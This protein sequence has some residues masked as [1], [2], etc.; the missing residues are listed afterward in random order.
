MRFFALKGSEKLG[1]AAARALA[2]ELDP[3]EE[4]DFEDGEH[5]ARPLVSVRGKDVYVL[6]SLA[7]SGGASAND[8]L[9]KLLFFLATCRENGAA[10]TTAV[11]PYLAYARK[12][13]QTKARDPVT[14][15]YVAQLFE[16]MGTDRVVTLDV[17]NFAAFQNAFRCESV[18]LDTRKLFAPLIGKL[19]GDLPVTIFSPD[20]G[21]VKRA[22]LL[23]EALEAETGREI[24]FG[25]ME[26]RRSRNVVS[27]ELFAGDVSGSAVFIVDD[28]IS[29]GGTMLRAA[30]A[31]RER[32]AKT[33]YAIAAHG[34]FGKGADALFE[35][36]AMDR[37]V[38]TDSVDSAVLAK[39]GY[40]KAR[41][42][43]LPIGRLI[44]EAIRLL[45][46]QGSISELVG[47][48]G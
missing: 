15:R 12:D 24:G 34:L 25:F 22:Q 14:T 33:V 27:G 21:G 40:P 16:A 41:L 17:H 9:C 45:H 32:G 44:G 19:T 37:I 29:T 47:I 35:S 31:C 28:M 7:G 36:P 46:T 43:I 13:R 8:R 11:V 5:K 2:I 18:H 1:A 39:T 30:L 4:R 10:Q 23:K 6:H 42:D 26:K 20:G 38:V 3:H 48:E